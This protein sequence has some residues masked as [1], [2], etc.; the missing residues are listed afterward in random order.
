[1]SADDLEFVEHFIEVLAAA[2]NSGDHHAVYPLLAPDVEWLTPQRHLYGIDEV[3]D[4][5]TW[6]LL[7]PRATL[8]VEVEAETT[9]HGGGRIVSD[10]HE[11]YR[12]KGTGDFA[13]ARDHRLDLTIR[14]GRI[15]RCEL[16][17]AG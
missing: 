3:R 9:D 8:E 1:M 15:A 10:I 14:E 5:A 6:P 17:F 7:S 11:T 2:A 4:Q 13:Y 16:R 12:V